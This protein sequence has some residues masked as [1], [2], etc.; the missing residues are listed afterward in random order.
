MNQLRETDEEY[1]SVIASYY[2][3]V[4]SSITRED[5]EEFI[6]GLPIT[7]MRKHVV[8]L[9]SQS[10]RYQRHS[11]YT[12]TSKVDG[13]RVLMFVN[14]RDSNGLRRIHFIDRNLAIFSLTNKEKYRLSAIEGP[15]ML[16]DGELVFYKK[17]VSYYHLLARETD[18]LTFMIF[19]ILYGPTSVKDSDGVV[20]YGS[21]N[22]I[23]GPMK[24]SHYDYSRRLSL[25]KDLI[26]PTPANRD[27]PP[28]SLS[29]GDN[30]FFK[31]ELKRV[32]YLSSLPGDGS[33]KAIHRA[34]EEERNQYYD[35]LTN[36]T[37]VNHDRYRKVRLS[38]DGLIFTPIDTPYVFGNWNKYLNAQ[39]KWKPSSEQTIDFHIGLTPDVY[40]PKRQ[41]TTYDV[42]NLSVLS[43]G[44]LTPFDYRGRSTGLIPDNQGIRD[45]TIGEFAYNKTLDAFVFNRLRQDKT[46]PNA[47]RTA[48]TVKESLDRPFDVNI[49]SQMYGTVD[50]Q[51]LTE[52]LSKEQ[53]ARILLCSGS[54][55]FIDSSQLQKMMMDNAEVEFRLGTVRSRRFDAG[56]P[57]DLYHRSGKLCDSMG[58]PY[59][60][61][62]Y[63]DTYRDNFRTRYMFVR[64]IGELV[65][66]DT[67]V[68][69]QVE[70][71]DVSLKG[72]T[73]FDVRLS[74]AIEENQGV[75][76]DYGDASKIME[77]KRLSYDGGVARVDLTEVR[78]LE[79]KNGSLNSKSPVTYQV[80]VETVG[81]D[82]ELTMAFVRRFLTELDTIWD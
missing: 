16:L 15:K 69:N 64:N 78:E 38:Y 23:A 13:T 81:Q 70:K 31:I 26:V 28:L 62:S 19:D 25:L 32:D 73:S 24:A 47:W 17:G 48:D 27:R 44:K 6:G 61:T 50:L 4:R 12:V 80:E 53:L 11:K 22:A 1:K 34:F 59:S 79:F 41:T 40:R 46:K 39:Y 55:K 30:P 14:E 56:V 18:Y 33:V 76:I 43:R 49:I 58:L 71:I 75:T 68:K 51:S 2:D 54:M 29:F 52:Y 8:A 42:V 65:K 72:V 67:I 21:A 45:G 74:M 60:M 3:L 35:F 37:G 63:V 20:T 57:N 36:A 10:R 82:A 77:K 5:K 9:L 66:V 7:L